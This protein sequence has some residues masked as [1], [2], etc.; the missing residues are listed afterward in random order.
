M[1]WRCVF[2]ALGLDA[3]GGEAVAPV[4]AAN[5]RRAMVGRYIV[6]EDGV[7]IALAS[8]LGDCDVVNGA[9]LGF[10]MVSEG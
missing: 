10:L 1:I 6:V 3:L 8:S 4:E 5:M 2:D 7:V 9:Y